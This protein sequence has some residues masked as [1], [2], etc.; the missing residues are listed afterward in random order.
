MAPLPKKKRNHA[1]QGKRWS[2]VALRAISLALCPQCRSPKPP[3][4]VCLTCGYY[5]GRQVV[6]VGTEAPARPT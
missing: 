5:R 4:R 2:H 1:R 3:H 6:A